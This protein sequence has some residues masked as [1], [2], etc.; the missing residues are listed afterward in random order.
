MSI[1]MYGHPL[2]HDSS[3]V[4]HIVNNPAAVIGLADCT[5]EDTV[6]L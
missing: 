4:I 3:M 2:K 1:A 6:G 5:S